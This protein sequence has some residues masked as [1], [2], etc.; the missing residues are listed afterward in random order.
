MSA[1]RNLALFFPKAPRNARISV[2]PAVAY[3]IR[4]SDARASNGR[5]LW[6]LEQWDVA[7]EFA[8]A[9]PAT[10]PANAT[11]DYGYRDADGQLHTVFRRVVRKP[12][13]E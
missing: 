10:V 1:D 4:T 7:Q 13:A 3:T 6:D 8:A 11:K 12:D 5:A 2:V 9:R